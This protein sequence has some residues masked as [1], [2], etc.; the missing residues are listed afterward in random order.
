MP[1]SLN[2]H[3]NHRKRIKN[4]FLKFGLTS[5]EDHE[6]LELMLTYV[7]PRKDTNPIGHNLLN[8]F[9]SLNNL[10]EADIKDIQ[11][12]SGMGPE[13]ALFIRLLSEFV[14]RI[15]I[16][17]TDNK[18]ILNTTA[19]LVRY[20]RKNFEV[21]VKEKF[22]IVCLRKNYLL[23]KVVEFEGDE[24]RISFDSR[25]FAQMVAGKDID[26]VAIFHTHPSGEARPSDEDKKATTRIKGICK[27]IG[28]K[29]V[30]HLIFNETEHYSFEH[31]TN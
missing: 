28:L 20:F 26:A 27:S 24:S 2:I 30:D 6:V 12:V 7:I 16:K 29:F 11:E 10:L 17:K 25:E 23:Y 21:G 13:S 14:Q 22:Y 1:G 18:L 4:K 3:K 15:N 8:T 9:G 5:F 19:K 31:S